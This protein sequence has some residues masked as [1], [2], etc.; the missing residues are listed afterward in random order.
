ML[1][2]VLFNKG[3]GGTGR[4]LPG[5]D[6]IS[7]MGFYSNTLPDGFTTESNI[8]TFYQPQDA[9]N[10]GILNDYSDAT[11]AAATY[12]I[13]NMGAVG[14]EI[15]IGVA[16]IDSDG[17]LPTDDNGNYTGPTIIA[18]YV[19]QSTDTSIAILG[20]S[21][22]AAINTGTFTNQYS[23]S[24]NSGTGVLTITA[25]KKFGIYLNSGSPV[26]VTIVG[27]IA[28]TLVQ[29]TG[30]VASLLAWWYYQIEEFFRI[31]SGG[32]LVV[33]YFPVV[34]E[35]TFDE[36]ALLQS[37]ATGT[38]RQVMMYK[39]FGSSWNQDDLQALHDACT[40][41]DVIHAPLSGIY[42]ADMMNIENIS[43]LPDNSTLTANKASDCIGMD[44]GGQGYFL[45]KTSGKS[46][47]A[48][49]AMLGTVALTTVSQ[50]IGWV[51]GFNISN[52][53][54]D[55]TLAFANGQLYNSTA[56]SLSL[57]NSLDNKRHVFLRKVIG[58]SGS[59]WN[60]GHTAIVSDSDYAYIEDNRTIDKSIRLIYAALVPALNQKLTLNP[61]GTLAD[62]TVTLL[63]T[64]PN[65]NMDSMVTAGDLSDY[66]III[67]PN[68]QILSTNNLEVTA[69]LE[70]EA[71]AR[72]ITVNIGFVPSI[73]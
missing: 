12:T 24:W 61:D 59:F 7:G 65:I 37:N 5:Q 39:D 19:R 51:G 56:I 40:S 43:S 62:T 60:G 29:F 34:E 10:A 23:A 33:G 67:N 25:P 47:P 63:E 16:D 8:R 27:T 21:I 22:A 13:T 4:P 9:V 41:E 2:D 55:E 18:S 42:G 44:G 70:Q 17:Y 26:T 30:G 50:S 35:Y 49:G 73:S 48:I 71:I 57:L 64:A 53:E 32:N 69:S 3:Q 11:A 66:A 14:D 58:Y 45:F 54:E 6:Y 20:A 38:L 1:P 68:Q 46:V 31:Q 15:E 72:Q 36:V 28:G 52:G